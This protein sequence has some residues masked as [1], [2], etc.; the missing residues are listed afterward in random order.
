MTPV[1][2]LKEIEGF[3]ELEI[4][5]ITYKRDVEKS[6]WHY[7]RLFNE[8]KKLCHQAEGADERSEEALYG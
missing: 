6:D 5:R 4:E 3:L 2:A 7:L 8:L 1:K